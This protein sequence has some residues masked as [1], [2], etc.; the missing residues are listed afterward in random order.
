LEEIQSPLAEHENNNPGHKIQTGSIAI[1][2]KEPRYFARKFKEGL[3][4]RKAKK[5]NIIMNRN[6]GWDIDSSWLPFLFKLI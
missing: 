4:I 2:D 5:T 1:I 3:H 6:D